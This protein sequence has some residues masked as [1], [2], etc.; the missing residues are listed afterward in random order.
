MEPVPA[1]EPAIVARAFGRAGASRWGLDERAFAHALAASVAHGLPGRPEP[2]EIQRYVDALHLDDLALATACALGDEGAWDHFVR[3][4]RPALYR[5]ADAVDPSGGARELADGLYA[6][7]FGLEAGA[8]HRR[9][10]LRHFHGRSRLTTWLRAVIAQRYVDRLRSH[11]RLVPL[12]DEDLTP[13]PARLTE[14]S[15]ERSRFVQLVELVFAAALAALTPRDRL[16]LSLYYVRDLTLA[17]IGRLLHEHEGTVSR[18]LTRTRRQL[19]TTMERDLRAAHGL[20]EA[21]IEACFQSVM[22][23]PGTLDLGRALGDLAVSTVPAGK[24]RLRDRSQ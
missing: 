10:L 16:R 21:A 11:R 19:R 5:A 6:D 3:E 22:D 2:S 23:D 1:L 24:N 7:L 13:S 4:F 17:Q 15:P 18:H 20:D 9:S 14:A 12:P 8:G